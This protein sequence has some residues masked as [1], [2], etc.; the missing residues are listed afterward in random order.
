MVVLYTKVLDLLCISAPP[1]PTYRKPIRRRDLVH[2]VSLLGQPPVPL[3]VVLESDGGYNA[4][5]LG[6]VLVV[7]QVQQERPEALLALYLLQ[8][9]FG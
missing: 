7:E 2:K 1:H 3:D 5:V 6:Q 9:L 8:V 4:E